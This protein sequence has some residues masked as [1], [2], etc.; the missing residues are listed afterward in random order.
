[1]LETENAAFFGTI[2]TEGQGKGI[3]IRIGDETVMGRIA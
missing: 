3:V 2:C 1:M